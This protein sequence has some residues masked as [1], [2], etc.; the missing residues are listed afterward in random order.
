MWL[1]SV[2]WNLKW[3]S[4]I[5][6]P[7]WL[8]QLVGHLYFSGMWLGLHTPRT[9]VY[10][11][12]W[13]TCSKLLTL[14]YSIVN[15]DLGVVWPSY[16]SLAVVTFGNLYQGGLQISM[17][18]NMTSPFTFADRPKLSVYKS[19]LYCTR[20]MGQNNHLRPVALHDSRLLMG[21]ETTLYKVVS[22]WRIPNNM[23]VMDQGGVRIVFFWFHFLRQK[24]KLANA[25]WIKNQENAPTIE[26]RG[27]ALE[28]SKLDKS[29]LQA[30]C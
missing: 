2:V 5:D 26:G 29:I 6:R 12:D 13:T 21:W 14:L 15:I 24:A 3:Y 1:K 19:K 9:H 10:T 4:N 23:L 22:K 8:L 27:G 20:N 18:L 30:C 28:G 16:G 17:R 7:H 25:K 11:T